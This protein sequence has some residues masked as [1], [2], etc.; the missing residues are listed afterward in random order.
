MLCPAADT[1]AQARGVPHRGVAQAA[2]PLLVY[3]RP[4]RYGLAQIRLPMP[5]QQ[6]SIRSTCKPAC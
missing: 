4:L 6:R 2:A 5:A 1:A 3:V